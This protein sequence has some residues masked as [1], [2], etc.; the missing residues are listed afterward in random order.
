M[1][2]LEVLEEIGLTKGEAEIWR[3]NLSTQCEQGIVCIAL[4]N[5]QD[6]SCKCVN[7]GCVE[8]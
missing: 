6:T 4:Y 1:I 3:T 5:C 8:E 2:N 7:G